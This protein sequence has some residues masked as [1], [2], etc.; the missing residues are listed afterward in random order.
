MTV[1]L[2]L[3]FGLFISLY[4]IHDK[5]SLNLKIDDN[6]IPM[7]SS[8]TISGAKE[9]YR[10]Y[11]EE[12]NRAE[13]LIV[14][15][16]FKDALSTYNIAFADFKNH[17]L[18]D[19]FN[20]SL[21]AVKVGDFDLAFNFIQELMTQGYTIE[22]FQ[23]TSFDSL[24][25]SYRK[26]I[27]VR[28]DSLTDIYKS[29]WDVSLK[30]RLDS[31]S[32]LE[33]DYFKFKK[34]FS[35]DSLV[36]EHAKILKGIIEKQGIPQV[37]MFPGYMKLPLDLLRHH[38]GVMN[39]YK[40]LLQSDPFYRKLNFKPYSLKDLL[41]TAV[42]NGEMTPH[43]YASIIEYNELDQNLT[44]GKIAISVDLEARVVKIL[45]PERGKIDLINKNRYKIGLES[46]ED[47]V[48]KNKDAESLLYNYPFNE[49]LSLC[50]RFGLNKKTAGSADVN[51]QGDFVMESN[52][53]QMKT[54]SNSSLKDFILPETIYQLQ[55]SLPE[56]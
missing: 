51:T 54:F 38:F 49:H 45:Y 34:T 41:L 48:S 10:K 1:K 12:I 19:L 22:Q 4:P 46:F 47:A 42:M 20:A 33:Q 13:L 37:P 53:L 35:Y 28:C 16:Q 27:N 26:L 56:N 11:Y 18:K 5:E 9:P 39:K 8:L 17:E 40:Y 21:C 31:L 15:H 52:K 55:L 36:Y 24:P 2:F 6:R 29:K 3:L 32:K 50:K 14:K 25:Q 30:T 43:L 23:K 7:S 44:T